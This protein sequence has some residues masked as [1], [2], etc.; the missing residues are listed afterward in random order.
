M[1]E[2]TDTVYERG[3]IIHSVELFDNV[4]R[5][6]DFSKGGQPPLA[7]GGEQ[8]TTSM[9]I[10]GG[11]RKQPTTSMQIEGGARMNPNQRM[12]TTR[13]KFRLPETDEPSAGEGGAHTDGKKYERT[14]VEDGATDNVAD[15]TMCPLI[16]RSR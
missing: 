7:E 8:P 6:L 14:A 4:G 11:A 16:L 3:Q 10:E 2:L 15:E 9:Q 13:T 12:K 5:V 1:S